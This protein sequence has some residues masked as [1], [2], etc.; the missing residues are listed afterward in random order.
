M[1]PLLAAL[2]VLHIS[3]ACSPPELSHEPKWIEFGIV[4]EDGSIP[5]QA[6]KSYPFF[7]PDPAAPG[8]I[9]VEQPLLKCRV[10]SAIP[11][12]DR[13]G[14][15]AVSVELDERDVAQFGDFTAANVNRE[16][17]VIVAGQIISKANIGERL[18]GMGQLHG[19]FTD[20]ERE[21]IFKALRYGGETAASR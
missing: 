8:P 11:S 20:E 15:P 5:M 14:K 1:K 13:H 3:V 17:V 12:L 21:W 16:M 6:G 9:R 7:K 4:A 19:E 2:A 18:P 10:A